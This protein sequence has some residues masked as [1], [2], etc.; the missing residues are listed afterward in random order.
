MKAVMIEV[1][2]YSYIR[3][4][5][6]DS[7]NVQEDDYIDYVILS[8]T[9]KKPNPFEQ[10]IESITFIDFFNKKYK[11]NF[12]TMY[13]PNTLDF[14]DFIL[15]FSLENIDF[16]LSVYTDDEHTKTIISQFKREYKLKELLKII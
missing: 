1:K 6:I 3:Y 13:K 2:N 9:I 5:I 12:Y 14:S 10:Y 15:L 7:E 4:D 8:F 11:S 16:D